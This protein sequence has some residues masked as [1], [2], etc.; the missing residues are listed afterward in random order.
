MRATLSAI[1]LAGL[2]SWS[3]PARAATDLDSPKADPS[4]H[5]VELENEWVRVVR[6]S[7]PPHEKTAMHDHPA[8]VGVYLTDGDLRLI[9]PDGKVT[10]AHPRAGSA[11][12]RG[13]TVH[14][15]ENVGDKV[16]EGL[17]VE[18]KGTA[19]PSWQPPANDA[20]KVGTTDRVEFE[21]E[22]VRI[23]R[24]VISKGERTPMHD[25]PSNVQILLTDLS[26]RNSTPDGKTT[27]A[28]G[29]AG[30]VRFRPPLTHTLENT[31]DRVEG[32]VIDLKAAPSR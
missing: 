32:I 15:A 27:E 1:V 19:N 20:P 4:H 17:L 26:G 23:L 21:N 25:H 24:F 29:K 22:Q 6:W 18:P 13:P 30:Q 9:A 31:G 14:V 5:R 16:V 7:I 2:V 3:G 8:L 28:A 12:W 11:A 10:E